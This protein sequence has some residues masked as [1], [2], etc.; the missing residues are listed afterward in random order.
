MTRKRDSDGRGGRWE[1][2]ANYNGD[3]DVSDRGEFVGRDKVGRDQIKVGGDFYQEQ[4]Y[5]R[6]ID[7]GDSFLTNAL[8]WLFSHFSHETLYNI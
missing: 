8:S 4:E 6:N 5:E 3:I 7:D 1:E 2:N